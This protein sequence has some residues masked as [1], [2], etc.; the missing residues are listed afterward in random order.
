MQ[1]LLYLSC[2]VKKQKDTRNGTPGL[3][4]WGSI[5]CGVLLIVLTL[6]CKTMKGFYVHLHL[7]VWKTTVL[8]MCMSAN[9][10]MK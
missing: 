9:K 3:L 4:G 1:F 7:G 2:I 10:I 6:T 8:I 5:P